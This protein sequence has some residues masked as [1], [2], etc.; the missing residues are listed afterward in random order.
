MSASTLLDAQKKFAQEYS[1]SSRAVVSAITGDTPVTDSYTGPLA[2]P[3]AIF[4][5]A[6]VSVVPGWTY[7]VSATVSKSHPVVNTVQGY[8]GASVVLEDSTGANPALAD[9][10]WFAPIAAGDAGQGCGSCAMTVK[11][12][13]GYDTLS[14]GNWANN[15]AADTQTTQLLREFSIVRIY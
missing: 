8:A 1:Y 12:P 7:R 11:I 13:T 9:A 4:T 2:A 10:F 3:G 15:A 5:G 6:S 14:I